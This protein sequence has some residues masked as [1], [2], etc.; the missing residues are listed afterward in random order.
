M[1]TT[2]AKSLTLAAIIIG[3]IAA[4]S[5]QGP[6]EASIATTPKLRL[7]EANRHVTFT[8]DVA[9]IFYSNCVQCHRPGDI[10]PM[11][12]LSYKE[13]RPWARSIREMVATRQ[14]PPWHADPRY[15]R[16]ANDKQLSQREIDTVVAWVDQDAAEGNPKDLPAVPAFVEGWEIGT[17]DV[18]LSMSEP[19]QVPTGGPDQYVY[20]TIPTNFKEDK[21]IAAAEIHPGNKAVVHH[22][23]AFVQPP[24]IAMLAKMAGG[25]GSGDG[26]SGVPSM[27]YKDGTLSRVRMDAR[28][29]DD[30]CRDASGGSSFGAVGAGKGTGMS[31]LSAYAP[32]KDVE[33]AAPGQARRI[34]A[35]SNIVFQV[36]YS[37]FRGAMDKP[38]SALSSI[39]LVFAKEPPAKMV[40]ALGITND[41]FKIP[42]GEPNHE[43]TACYTV[44]RDIQAIEY[45]PHMHLRGKEMKYE[46][47]YPDGRRETL[48][49]VPQYNFNWQTIY[50]LKE[51]VALPGGTKI[52]IT[53][54]FDNSERNK[55]NPDP[56]KAVRWGDPT[57]DEMMIGWLGYTV[58]A[59]KPKIAVK[60]EPAIYDRYA[61]E[62]SFSPKFKV[63]VVRS[64]DKLMA[65]VAGLPPVELMPESETRFFIRSLDAEVSF[66]E[67]DGGRVTGLT[68]DLSGL[69]LSAKRDAVS[70]V[71]AVGH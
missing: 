12:L 61:G 6:G 65:Q 1:T 17:P 57:Y 34:P 15:G 49:W 21:W 29:I 22:V 28:I 60:V 53:A 58:D 9:P 64:G 44:D 25:G 40:V 36:H 3:S 23:M 59:P 71:T 19:Y 70:A 68:L 30:G 2:I 33:V 38:E 14:M 47:F 37:N 16:F 48:L 13:A 20:F 7:E 55:Y 66:N 32:G 8:K 42:P 50:K 5:P 4:V 41:Y 27:Y 62:Y 54:H 10:A 52:V 24:A 35:G 56:A 43:V 69:V 67:A 51:P 45:M 46:A 18:I 31:L 39:G 63:R 26:N 11:S